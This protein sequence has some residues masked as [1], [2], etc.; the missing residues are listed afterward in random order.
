MHGVTPLLRELIDKMVL[1]IPRTFLPN[2]LS[3][4]R[5]YNKCHSGLD[6]ESSLFNLDSRF[7]GNDNSKIIVKMC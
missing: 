4:R 2:V 6:P 7:R 5:V 3:H 1:L